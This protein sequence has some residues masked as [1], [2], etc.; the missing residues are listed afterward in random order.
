[1]SQKNYCYNCDEEL[2]KEAASVEHIFP[3]AIGG[4]WRSKKILCK[5]CNTKLGSEVDAYLCKD[6]QPFAALLQIDRQRGALPIIK[7]AVSPSG[8]V[9]NLVE[10]RKPV[11][12]KPIVNIDREKNRIFISV[13]D[14]K[15]LNIILKQL[16]KKFPGLDDADIP[17][18]MTRHSEYLDESLTLSL[19]VGGEAFNYAVL[20][21]ALSAWMETF[22]DPIAVM[23]ALTM[24][25]SRSSK[26]ALIVKHYYTDE[27]IDDAQPDEVSHVIYFK[28]DPR[29]KLLYAYIELFSSYA[30]TVD[31]NKNY[32]GPEVNFCYRYDVLKK[33][34]SDKQPPINY[35]GSW[36]EHPN[37]NA[38][39]IQLLQSKL[40]RVLNIADTR[41]SYAE[42]DEVI[43]NSIIE[44]FKQFP[45]DKKFSP[46]MRA[47]LVKELTKKAAP[48]IRRITEAS[49]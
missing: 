25:K 31:L 29:E 1:V 14:E 10:G 44:V 23:P 46:E 36:P 40:N 24:F 2:T 18:K 5:A 37:L 41:Q 8:V 20:K 21:I 49:D 45:N 35:R 12:S 19:S 38:F 43:K 15:Q 3:N 28:G 39:L 22:N 7:N 34:V 26:A 17:S 48:L 42:I 11:N 33:I 16:K 30:F 27:L 6:L 47:A 9:Y 32:N 4:M 13:P